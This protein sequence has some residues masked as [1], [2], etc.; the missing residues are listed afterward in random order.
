MS[1]Q[2]LAA[3]PLLHY[4]ISGR[5]PFD[6]EDSTYIIV[7][8]SIK[9]ALLQFEANIYNDAGRTDQ[10]DVFDANA[11]SVFI[12]SI[13]ASAYPVHKISLQH[14]VS[15]ILTKPS[16]RGMISS[17]NEEE[18]P[19]QSF[20]VDISRVGYY[21]SRTVGV[22]ASSAM[23]ARAKALDSAGDIDF[24]SEFDADYQVDSVLA[25]MESKGV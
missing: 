23:E 12:N 2:L 25:V 8:D 19:L 3:I 21:K 18:N 9:S 6:D 7:A 16:E 15:D 10:D 24:G 5:I 4:I 14:Q 11:E 17:G 22:R 1:N 13:V 20:N